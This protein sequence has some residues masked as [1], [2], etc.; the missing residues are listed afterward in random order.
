MPA[1]SSEPA[2]A[3]GSCAE[4]EGVNDMEAKEEQSQQRAPRRRALHSW[5]IG[6]IPTRLKG[7]ARRRQQAPGVQWRT[8][9]G[10][11]PTHAWAARG[12]AR[13]QRSGPSG[14]SLAQRLA[15]AKHAVP[16]MPGPRRAL[17]FVQLSGPSGPSRPHSVDYPGEGEFFSVDVDWDHILGPKAAL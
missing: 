2:P 10:A 13:V 17:A 5:H 4:G 12:L 15:K 11:A 16:L 9:A 7:P 3:R 1:R 14:P 6:Q 8:E